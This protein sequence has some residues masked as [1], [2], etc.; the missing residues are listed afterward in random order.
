MKKNDRIGVG[1]FVIFVIYYLLRYFGKQFFETEEEKLLRLNSKRK[2]KFTIQAYFM[3]D[4][5]NFGLFF[6][7]LGFVITI[8]IL[9]YA[10]FN[11]PTDVKSNL[12]G[13]LPGLC[14]IIFFFYLI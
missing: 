11:K 4:I 3:K 1:A 7:S 12:Y 2:T 14:I 10:I 9:F 8:S 6:N 13:S 5:Q